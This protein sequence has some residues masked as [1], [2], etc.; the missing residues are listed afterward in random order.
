MY[1][2]AE[3]TQ[4]VWCRT[5][6]PEHRSPREITALRK[7]VRTCFLGPSVPA[8]SLAPWGF[9]EFS[10]GLSSSP[11]CPCLQGPESPPCRRWHPPHPQTHVSESLVS[12]LLQ[13][14]TCSLSTQPSPCSLALLC[15][16][17]TCSFPQVSPSSRNATAYITAKPSSSFPVPIRASSE[18]Q[19][20]LLDQDLITVVIT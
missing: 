3:P 8:S 20:P 5:R 14:G 11:T 18:L 1:G 10:Q 17:S 15:R 6:A 9:L 19:V 16:T 12:R 7:Q 13:V 2:G 4:L